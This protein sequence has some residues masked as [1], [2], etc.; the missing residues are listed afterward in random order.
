MKNLIC[1]F[2]GDRVSRILV[3]L[4]NWLWGVPLESED[5][6]A[7]EVAQAS[8]CTMQQSVYQLMEAVATVT[9]TYQRTKEKYQSRQ[10]EAQL[11]E[12]RAASAYRN[13]DKATARLAMSRAIAIERILPQLADQVAQAEKVLQ[14]NQEKLNR[15][16]QRLET[17]KIEMQ[18]L[19]DL[20]EVSAALTVISEINQTLNID[21]ARSQF[22]QAHAVVEGQYQRINAFAELSESP[23]EKLTADLEKLTL[24]DEISHRLKTLNESAE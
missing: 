17:Y 23:S 14:S 4:W 2:M 19:K 9:A 18:N 22:E 24:E 6:V 7:V 15:E 12:Q 10:R 13:G 8:L 21:S 1:W 11:A 16:R 5:K 3:S 20:S